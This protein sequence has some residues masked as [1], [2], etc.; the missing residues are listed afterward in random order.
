MTLDVLFASG[1]TSTAIRENA[2]ALCDNKGCHFCGATLYRNTYEANNLFVHKYYALRNDQGIG[3]TNDQVILFSGDKKEIVIRCKTT[4]MLNEYFRFRPELMTSQDVRPSVNS[5]WIK[6]KNEI[7]K[8]ATSCDEARRLLCIIDQWELESLQTANVVNT[9]MKE[10]GRLLTDGDCVF[11]HVAGQQWIWYNEKHDQTFV[12]CGDVMWGQ[13]FLP[14]KHWFF[15]GVVAPVDS[16]W[17]IALGAEQYLIR[18]HKSNNRG[19]SVQQFSF[20]VGEWERSGKWTFWPLCHR[21]LTPAGRL[22]STPGGFWE[23]ASKRWAFFRHPNAMSAVDPLG[24]QRVCDIPEEYGH[25]LFYCFGD[26]AALVI[27]QNDSGCFFSMVKAGR[28]Q[29]LRPMW[30]IAAPP[31]GSIDNIA[32]VYALRGNPDMFAIVFNLD[33]D[34]KAFCF[35]D[36]KCRM[37]ITPALFLANAVWEEPY[38]DCNQTD[39][40]SIPGRIELT[41]CYNKETVK[42][43]VGMRD[44]KIHFCIGSEIVMRGEMTPCS[45]KA[46]TRWGQLFRDFAKSI[47]TQARKRKA[48]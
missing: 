35:L 20:P 25:V 44:R 18:W 28:W 26:N 42:T 33:Q 23:G 14:V 8:Q 30:T 27:H 21:L 7:A 5:P 32:G 45:N 13:V 38:C 2:L 3:I 15:S 10:Q 36:A 19:V 29:P 6:M 40:Q 9:I 1:K 12:G 43:S 48:K 24:N 16:G 47:T 11:L 37:W 4:E 46:K 41:L 22:V 39:N 17:L 31:V 34:K